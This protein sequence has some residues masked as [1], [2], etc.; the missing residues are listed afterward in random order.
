MEVADGVGDADA[1]HADGSDGFVG[2][3]GVVGND[4]AHDVVSLASVGAHVYAAVRDANVNDANVAATSNPSSAVPVSVRIDV[5][6]INEFFNNDMLL[7]GNFFDIIGTL[8]SISKFKSNC[9]SKA[10]TAHL[11]KQFTNPLR[12]L[13]RFF[14]S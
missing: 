7:C 2:D 8:R 10:F 5:E 1:M 6:P 4:S 9:L 14:F 3:V 13:L 11:L 12:H